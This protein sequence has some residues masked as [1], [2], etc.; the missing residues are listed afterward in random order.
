MTKRPGRFGGIGSSGRPPLRVAGLVGIVALLILDV[1]LVYLALTAHGTASGSAD[2]GGSPASTP[3]PSQPPPGE[4]SGEEPDDGE[5]E[6][7]FTPLRRLLAPAGNT[8][9]WRATTEDCESPMVVQRT[10]DGGAT[11]VDYP[12]QSDGGRGILALAAVDETGLR[13]VAGVGEDC[14]PVQLESFTSGQ[15]WQPAAEAADLWH[16]PP[17]DPGVLIAPAGA[18]TAPCGPVSALAWRSND[19]AAVA[20]AD[21]SLFLTADSGATWVDAG[22]GPGVAAV[23]A[24]DDGYTVARVGDESCD[25]LRIAALDAEGTAPISCVSSGSSTDVAMAAG[26]GALWIWAGDEVLVSVDDGLT[27]PD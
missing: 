4:Q 19:E 16:V 25:G 9:A 6:F 12:I 21:G 17:L 8:I 24:A 23:A 1:V 10:G 26:G 20:C 15:F 14:D 18:V 13:A 3:P 2:A 11:W 27:W 5:P 22:A 7:E